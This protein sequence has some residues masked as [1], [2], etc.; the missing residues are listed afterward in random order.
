MPERPHPQLW[1]CGGGGGGGGGCNSAMSVA[2]MPRRC[3]APGSLASGVHTRSL[4]S[5]SQ[6]TYSIAEGLNMQSQVSRSCNV[7]RSRVVEG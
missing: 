4:K 6:S 2:V 3:F 7:V 5:A 1:G